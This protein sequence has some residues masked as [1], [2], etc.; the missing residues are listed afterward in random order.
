M[1]VMEFPNNYITSCL[2]VSIKMHL[3]K[4]FKKNYRMALHE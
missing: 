2:K 4:V 3:C 1:C